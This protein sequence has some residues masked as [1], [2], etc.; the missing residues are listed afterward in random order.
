MPAPDDPLWTF[1]ASVIGYDAARAAPVPFVR[2]PLSESEIA[3]WTAEPRRY[4]FHA[5]LQA[6]FRLAE[7]RSAEEL[8]QAAADFAAA[9][10][11]FQVP[12]LQ[13]ATMGP[14]IAL[15][16]AESSEAIGNL[17]DACVRD[18]DRFRAPMM[19]QE[20]ER[21]LKS[22]LTARQASQLE[23]WGYP[24]VFEDFRFHMTLSGPLHESDR[25]KF[26]QV[27]EDL[28]APLHDARPTLTIDGLA[29]YRQ[30]APSEKFV[31][32]DRFRFTGG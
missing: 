14:F 19:P 6:P 31:V 8:R 3:A 18:F 4:G 22:P 21:R 7:G 25:A 16:P 10:P 20:R 2:S 9:H 11:S 26:M 23:E 1:G 5:T 13:L 15:I 27:L 17:A 24:Y 12:A 30:D 32:E 29:V 28:Y